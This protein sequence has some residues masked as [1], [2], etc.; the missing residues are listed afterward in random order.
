[1]IEDMRIRG[2]GASQQRSHIRAV[3]EFAGFMGRSP[4]TATADEV[5]AWQLKLVDD[6]VSVYIFN[7]RLVALR[8]FFRATCGREDMERHMPLRRQPSTSPTVLSPEEVAPVLK[9]A[10]GPGLEYR[11]A[12]TWNPGAEM[13]R[14]AELRIETGLSIFFCDP[15]SPWQRGSS[16]NTNGL[17]RQSFPK[18]AD[19]AAH[20]AA[21]LAAVALDTRPRKT[22]GW[23]TPAEAPDGVLREANNTTVATT[24]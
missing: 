17:L 3:R 22:P 12:L 16:E 19:L 5:R 9:A 15:H 20:D 13:A 8:F 10:P 7:S 11:A 14:H 21:H 2:L 4:D 6:G 24:G 18:G 1:M 23:R